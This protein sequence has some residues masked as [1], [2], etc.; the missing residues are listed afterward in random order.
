MGS[1]MAQLDL[2][3]SDLKRQI[4]DFEALYFVKGLSLAISYY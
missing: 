4:Q 1:P 3:L 2:T